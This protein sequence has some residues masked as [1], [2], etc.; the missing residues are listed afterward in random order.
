[1]RIMGVEVCLG[2]FL[3]FYFSFASIIFSSAVRDHAVAI[4]ESL[5]VEFQK[6]TSFIISV[7]LKNPYRR[8]N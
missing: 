7:Y 6:S 4:F 1:M 2:F 8:S 5:A 3:F